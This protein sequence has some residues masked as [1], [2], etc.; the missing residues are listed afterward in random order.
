MI[1]EKKI[2]AV[3]G[4]ETEVASTA[5]AI[6]KNPAWSI[7]TDEQYEMIGD[8]LTDVARRLKAIEEFR[9]SIVGPFVDAQRNAN[10]KFKIATA[11]LEELERILRDARLRFARERD[12]KRLA[13]MQT[14]E[15]VPAPPPPAR[16][17]S[18][19]TERRFEIVDPDAVPHQFCSPDPEKIKAHMRDGGLQA[20]KGVRFYDHVVEVVRT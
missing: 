9:K 10:A 11:P 3:V 4:P 7:Q 18:T 14:A 8:R 20:I 19:R 15:V 13:A 5:L 12:A 2:Q 17:I 16:N 6:V 1:D